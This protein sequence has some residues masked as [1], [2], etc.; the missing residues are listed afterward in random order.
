MESRS[1]EGKIREIAVKA[2]AHCGVDFVH[3]ELGGTK[4][5]QIV[6]IFA[7]KEG[8]ISIEDCSNVSKAVEAAMDADDF[9]PAAYIL[10][11]S[12]PGLDRELYS[13]SDFEKFTGKL[14]KIKMKPGFEGPKA[15]NGRIIKVEG[16]AIT[17]DDRTASELVFSFESVAKANLKIDIEQE[18][19]RR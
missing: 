10:E 5:N 17:F 2:T 7:D 13:L 6:R 15:L 1:I 3:L 18:L 9:M 8:G 16:S 4:R 14:A 19:N 12:S 11:V